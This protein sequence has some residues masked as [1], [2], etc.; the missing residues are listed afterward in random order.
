MLEK[1]FSDL[2]ERIKFAEGFRA[3]PYL[4]SEGVPTIGYGTTSVSEYE[5]EWLLRH[6]LR[7][8]VELVEG[9]LENEQISLDE[10]RKMILCE[11]CYQLGFKGLMAFKK[12][13]RAIRD[14]DYETASR[15]MLNSVW[16]HQTPVRCEYL[17]RK[18]RE[19]V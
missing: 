3:K 19:G 15:E 2:C 7:E 10:F 6:R 18:M 5:A 17:A 12:M 9:Y 13:W 4:C 8:C 14:F 1:G 16:H 11:M